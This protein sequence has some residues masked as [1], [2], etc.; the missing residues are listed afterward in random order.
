MKQTLSKVSIQKTASTNGYGAGVRP[1]LEPFSSV[2]LHVYEP[3]LIWLKYRRLWRK[4][5]TQFKL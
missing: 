3:S 2:G 4:T 1:L 5:T